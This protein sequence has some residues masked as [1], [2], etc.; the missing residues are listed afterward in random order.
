METIPGRNPNTERRL[1][2]LQWHGSYW[3]PQGAIAQAEQYYSQF[4][5]GGPQVR[6]WLLI[7]LA[8]VYYS[9]ASSAATIAKHIKVQNRFNIWGMIKWNWK[10]YCLLKKAWQNAQQANFIIHRVK[11]LIITS[12]DHDVVQS[13]AR[14]FYR[15]LL[16]VKPTEYR[17]QLILDIA[18][19]SIAQALKLT[20]CTGTSRCFLLIGRADMMYLQIGPYSEGRVRL[21]IFDTLLEVWHIAMKEVALSGTDQQTNRQLSRL[22]RQIKEMCARLPHFHK[23][24]MP[25]KYDSYPSSVEEMSKQANQLM[26]EYL[27]LGES[28]DQDLKADLELRLPTAS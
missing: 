22:F 13:I 10:A 26:L 11:D 28:P 7:S 16:F 20:D 6:L 3:G 9:A 25:S 14:K 4:S 17:A 1:G 2:T 5:N 27:R 8:S 24:I 12:S 18:E 15:T 19:Y 23:E 21:A